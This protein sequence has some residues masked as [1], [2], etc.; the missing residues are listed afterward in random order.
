MTEPVSHVDRAV[1]ARIAAARVQIQ[2]A[3]TQREGFA[4]ARKRGL[5]R[6]HAQKLRNL[7]DAERRAQQTEMDDEPEESP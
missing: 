4:A 5:A 2:A 6:R 1:Q 7:A 3:K